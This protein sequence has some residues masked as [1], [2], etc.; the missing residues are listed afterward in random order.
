MA[1]LETTLAARARSSQTGAGADTNVH[2]VVHGDTLAA[3][4][5]RAGVSLRAL[6]AANPQIANPDRIY[7]GDRIEVPQS[8]AGVGETAGG[9]AAA[10]PSLS[11]QGLDLV[12]RFEGLRLAAYQD[13]AGVWTIGYGHTGNV[14]PGQRITEAQAE[15]LLR[16]DVAWAE[17]A[18][19]KNVDVPLSQG[20]F[21]ALVSFTFNLGSGAL[22]RSTLLKKLNAGDYAGAQAE[23]G[24][25]VHAGGR[26]LPGL[27][28]RRADEAA[29]FGSGEPANGRPASDNAAMGTR[30]AGRPH[31]LTAASE[32]Y[33]F[34]EVHPSHRYR[35]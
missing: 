7:P 31:R 27:V 19:R 20:Q 16:K 10:S 13:S 24:R 25:F 28:R 6:I 3:I 4:A 9:S 32:G 2:V 22:Q 12:K 26:V 33:P 1:A 8:E 34:G 29:L 30:D 35:Q 15:Q 21:D 5:A 18:V 17:D 11:A 23:F 14:R